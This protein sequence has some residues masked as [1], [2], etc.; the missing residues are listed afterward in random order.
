MSEVGKLERVTSEGKDVN[1]KGNSPIIN[2]CDNFQLDLINLV[3]KKPILKIWLN[4]LECEGLWDTGSMI[5][6]INK[7]VLEEKFPELKMHSVDTFMGT[8]V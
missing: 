5:S 3:G 7:K 2:Y 8:G 6:L 1:P 4:Q